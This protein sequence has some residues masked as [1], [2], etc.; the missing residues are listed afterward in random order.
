M[1]HVA[2]T[3]SLTL[4]AALLAIWLDLRIGDG[5]PDGVGRRVGH[6]VVGFILL[7][8]SSSLLVYAKDHGL[9]PSKLMVGVLLLFA[10]ALIYA[11]LT[12]LWLMRTL[13]DVARFARR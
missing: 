5:R 4:A 11:L 12:G 8:L 10:P 13:A 2:F 9:A 3:T 6:A 1:S 7:Q